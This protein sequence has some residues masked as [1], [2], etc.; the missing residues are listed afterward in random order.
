MPQ[1]A[2][3]SPIANMCVLSRETLSNEGFDEAWLVVYKS[4]V[5][6]IIGDDVCSRMRAY[7]H[8]NKTC[9][10][11]NDEIS[12]LSDVIYI[13]LRYLLD[14]LKPIVKFWLGIIDEINPS[15]DI[16]NRIPES[17]PKIANILRDWHLKG[18]I[19]V[20]FSNITLTNQFFEI[21][22]S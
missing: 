16:S 18:Y 21:F 4:I 3:E 11:T 12:S 5:Y 2:L 15:C 1:H 8:T 14:E 7:H 17:I 22:F 20:N 10:M 6:L 13:P 9:I 19:R